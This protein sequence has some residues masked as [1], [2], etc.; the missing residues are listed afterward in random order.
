VQ[1]DRAFHAGQ[2]DFGTARED[3]DNQAVFEA[4]LAKVKARTE[5]PE[6]PGD[7]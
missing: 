1:G 7:R 4:F 3:A 6:K 5:R 2:F